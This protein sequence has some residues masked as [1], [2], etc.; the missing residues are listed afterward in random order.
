VGALLDNINHVA[1]VTADLDRLHAFYCGALGA[2]IE[3]QHEGPGFRMSVI[4]L[5]VASYLNCFE[6]PDREHARARGEMFGRGHLDHLGLNA[7]DEDAFY[8]LRRRLMELGA[9]TD[10][11]TDFGPQISFMYTDP[12]G[13]EG[14]ICL[15]LDP[16]VPSHEPRRY[17]PRER[18]PAAVAV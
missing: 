8:E 14:E 16:S 17:E 7:R 3:A 4:Q 12:D 11:I 10:E 5:G 15:A 9:C 1:L 6:L 18:S 2:T 13:M